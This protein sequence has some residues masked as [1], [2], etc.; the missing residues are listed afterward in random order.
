M[1]KQKHTRRDFLKYAL[2]TVSLSTPL[3]SCVSTKT[4]PITPTEATN[5]QD[6]KPSTIYIDEKEKIAII[7]PV[8]GL[9]AKTEGWIKVSLEDANLSQYKKAK[10]LT[11]TEDGKTTHEATLYHNNTNSEIKYEFRTNN[12]ENIFWIEKKRIQ[13]G[14]GG[15]DGNG[16]G[17]SGGGGGGGSGGGNGGGGQG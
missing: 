10:K 6:A 13:I 8:G 17:G 16:G 7:D 4:T 9:E 12:K 15:S 11:S 14:G 2:Y 1:T 3:A 5:L